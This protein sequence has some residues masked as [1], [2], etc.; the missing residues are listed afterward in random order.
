[1]EPVILLFSVWTPWEDWDYLI[2]LTCSW[3]DPAS[4]C[5]L[6]GVA[7]GRRVACKKQQGRCHCTR[8]VCSPVSEHVQASCLSA[9][10]RAWLRQTH[11]QMEAD[12]LKCLKCNESLS[13]LL[14]SVCARFKAS[15]SSA[16]IGVCLFF[17][18]FWRAVS[19]VTWVLKLHY[20]WSS[21]AAKPG[22]SVM[23]VKH[24]SPSLKPELDG[25]YYL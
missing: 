18:S 24:S 14:Q 7:A 10:V 17:F 12:W 1:M 22:S 6:L 15:E 23:V 9:R 25:C 11:A 21:V 5:K 2:P 3:N 4:L 8:S 13:V 19:L 16:V 20:P